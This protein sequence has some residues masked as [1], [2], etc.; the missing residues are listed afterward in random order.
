MSDI[1]REVMEQDV[2]LVGA[3][4]ANLAC[5][6]KLKQLI[7]KHNESASTPLSAEISL[8]EKAPEIGHH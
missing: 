6:I 5:A 1:E 2:L 3:G 4:P 7:N 8:I